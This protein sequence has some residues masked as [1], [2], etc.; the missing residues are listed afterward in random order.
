MNGIRV[1][2]RKKPNWI[3]HRGD[4]RSVLATLKPR[5]IQTC[6]TSPP[7]WGLRKYEGVWPSVWGDGWFGLLGLEPTIDQY[8]RNIVECFRAVRRV[9]RDDGTLWLNMGDSYA[10]G[11]GGN[12]GSG[13][14]VAQGPKHTTS[15]QDKPQSSL[16]AKNLI[17]QPWRV[18]FAL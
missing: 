12:Y 1:R 18:A 14:S 11:G 7:Y 4:C 3:V 10:G 16:P 13:L 5:S 2:H 15:G 8:V 6:V 9:L 17:G